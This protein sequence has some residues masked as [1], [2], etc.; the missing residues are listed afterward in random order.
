M[1][2][3]IIFQGGKLLRTVSLEQ[4]SVLVGRRDD[5]EIALDHPSVSRNHARI[6]EAGGRWHVVDDGSTNGIKVNDRPLTKASLNHGDQIQV[7]AFAIHFQDESK[8]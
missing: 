2:S 5:A 6:Y 8:A 1:A 3:V 4:P 7:G